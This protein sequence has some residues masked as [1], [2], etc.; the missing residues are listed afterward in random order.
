MYHCPSSFNTLSS[1]RQPST[2]R[3]RL[4]GYYWATHRQ[5]SICV[6]ELVK[7]LLYAAHGMWCTTW[8]YCMAGNIGGESNLV[9]WWSSVGMLNFK[10][11][12]FITWCNILHGCATDWFNL[13]TQVVW[14]IASS[15]VALI[16]LAN[17]GCRLCQNSEV[18]PD[19]HIHIMTM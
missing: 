13:C 18:W 7:L 16:V 4:F 1:S 2:L 3:R 14:K 15:A 12:N 19:I 6:T 9:N 10:L 11:P 5:M 17:L 8:I